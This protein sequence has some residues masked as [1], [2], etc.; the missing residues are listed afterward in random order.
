MENSKTEVVLLRKLTRKSIIGFG[1]YCGCPVSQII[2][3][4]NGRMLVWYYYNIEGISFVDE[5]LDELGITPDIRIKK[6]S[7]DPEK[8]DE[9]FR[10]IAKYKKGLTGWIVS[11]KAIA[12]R[13][14]NF[15]AF[16]RI[17]RITFSKDSL[18]RSNHGD[19]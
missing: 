1:K 5:L 10:R 11:H 13:K 18:R 12:H 3:S 15:V 8:F 9:Y 14:R 17:D 6:P 16:A 4:N 2:E 7:K 19:K